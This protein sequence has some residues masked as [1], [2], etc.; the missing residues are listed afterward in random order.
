MAGRPS[1]LFRAFNSRRCHE[2]NGRARARRL[3]AVR[4]PCVPEGTLSVQRARVSDYC[5]IRLLLP[6]VLYVLAFSD[7][8]RAQRRRRTRRHQRSRTSGSRRCRAIRVHTQ[9]NRCL[10]RMAEARSGGVEDARESNVRRY[11]GSAIPEGCACLY[12]GMFVKRL[13]RLPRTFSLRPLGARVSWG[14]A[15]AGARHSWHGSPL[16]GPRL[17]VKPQSP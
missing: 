10:R 8:R 15:K 11:G 17:A 12:G 1:T 16:L 4:L 2:R 14:F 6:V 13:E 3:H 7:Q 5:P 9:T